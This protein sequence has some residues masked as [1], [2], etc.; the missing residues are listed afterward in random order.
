MSESIA[1]R[2]DDSTARWLQETADQE[3]TTV[4]KLVASILEQYTRDVDDE[5]DSTEL[6]IN[7]LEER[8]G[9][10]E[11]NIRLLSEHSEYVEHRIYRTG[12]LA[13]SMGWTDDQLPFP[14]L[15]TNDEGNTYG[16]D[17]QTISSLDELDELV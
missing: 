4:S 13:R 12:K 10:I 11:Q 16:D 17:K 3:D 2:V 9:E 5:P 14:R 7:Q 8:I 6:R 15:P 1:A